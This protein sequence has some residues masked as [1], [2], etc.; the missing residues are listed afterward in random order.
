MN[1]TDADRTLAAQVA[2]PRTERQYRGTG[3]YRVTVGG[4]VIGT[5]DKIEQNDTYWI[6]KDDD[7]NL[8]GGVHRTRT[9]A[10]ARLGLSDF[11]V[12]AYRDAALEGTFGYAEKARVQAALDAFLAAQD[13]Q[14]EAVEMKPVGQRESAAIEAELGRKAS[15]MMIS[16]SQDGSPVGERVRVI[17]QDSAYR[18]KVGT[19]VRVNEE[20]Y[21]TV[22]LEDGSE[23]G[24][25]LSR[26]GLVIATVDARPG[27]KIVA[28]G[29]EQLDDGPTVQSPIEHVGGEDGPLGVR[30][31][32]PRTTVVYIYAEMH[33]EITVERP[34]S[35]RTADNY[36]ELPGDPEVWGPQY[37]E[38]L[39]RF[40]DDGTN[41]CL[42][43]RPTGGKSNTAMVLVSIG[44][45]ALP[46]ADPVIDE[47]LTMMCFPVGSECRKTLPAEYVIP[48]DSEKN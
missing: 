41:C 31:V 48:A 9:E 37:Y 1:I 5:V 23:I 14:A 22:R 42:C 19:V 46:H 7:G 35:K 15:I 20:G 3:T 40:G 36:Y 16:A 29:E 12:K 38:N 28:L 13:E 2:R 32:T 33:P 6:A 17:A 45:K 11:A 47:D 10:V 8:V 25:H 26:L 21:A 39:R 24:P 44:G 30:L 4:I 34:A 43:G 18:G 27:D